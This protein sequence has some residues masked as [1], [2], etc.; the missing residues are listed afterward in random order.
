MFPGIAVHDVHQNIGEQ[1][2]EHYPIAPQ[3]Q[4]AEGGAQQNHNGKN[5]RINA[6]GAGGEGALTFGWVPPVRFHIN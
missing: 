4:Q 3:G 2:E 1:N 6:N 5:G